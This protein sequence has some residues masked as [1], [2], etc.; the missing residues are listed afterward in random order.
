[1]IQKANDLI[2]LPYLL[3]IDNHNETSR[4]PLEENSSLFAGSGPNCRIPLSGKNIA[5]I[6]CMIW[7]NES[8]TI[9]VQDWNTGGETFVNGESISEATALKAGDE[10]QIGEY[11]I[12]P[13]L[14]SSQHAAAMLINKSDSKSTDR[15]S[16]A[17]QPCEEARNSLLPNQE[18][19]PGELEKPATVPSK[20]TIAATSVDPLETCQ[21]DSSSQGIPT[22]EPTESQNDCWLP[23]IEFPNRNIE[24]SDSNGARSFVAQSLQDN[25]AAKSQI[26]FESDFET[27]FEDPAN[28]CDQKE[29]IEWL[30]MEVE[31]LRFALAE[32]DSNSGVYSEFNTTGNVESLSESDDL[33]ALDDNQTLRLVNRLEELLEELRSS[34]DRVRGLEEVLELS[35]QATQAEREERLQLV[36]WVSEIED[37]VANRDAESVAELNRVKS[38]LLDSQSRYR[39]TQ[40]QLK[41]LTCTEGKFVTENTAELLSELQE[42][43]ENLQL[44]LTK[45][46]EENEKLQNLPD[47]KMIEMEQQMLEMQV[48]TSR[49]RAET[50]RQRAELQR[51]KDG[52]EQKLA[53]SGTGEADMRI[54]AMREHLRE[55][56]DAEQIERQEQKQTGLGGRISRLLNRVGR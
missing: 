10:L 53:N 47:D 12:T 36:S 37:R 40:S 11:Q 42:Q 21:E 26:D 49:E 35:D 24:K 28:D 55:I 27:S 9:Q 29:E 6:H 30:K 31:Q 32:Q 56:H 7:S 41:K 13:I 50:A 33:D 39:V 16:K 23:E 2:Q 22:N 17:A 34:D 38:Q 18:K 8:C 3:I 20:L 43:I 48:V 44:Q 54:R 4:F 25:D 46:N 5:D 14:T 52:L 19:E 1:M 15:V 51:L 45:S